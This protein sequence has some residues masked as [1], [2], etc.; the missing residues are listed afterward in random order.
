[1]LYSIPSAA[2]CLLARLPPELR[3]QIYEYVFPLPNH[4]NITHNG[5]RE[6]LFLPLITFSPGD[7]AAARAIYYSQ[8]VFTYYV[9]SDHNLQLE[10]GPFINRLLGLD[11]DTMKSL[12]RVDV[13]CYCVAALSAEL[14][15]GVLK[16]QTKSAFEERSLKLKEGVVRVVGKDEIG[17]WLRRE[18]MWFG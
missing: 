9:A 15:L 17:D 10:F 1:M 7:V 18:G 14:I 13:V 2:T 3:L 5:W 4:I 8:N 12:T 6:P 11:K 16:K